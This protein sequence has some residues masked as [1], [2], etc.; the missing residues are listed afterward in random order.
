MFTAIEFCAS[1]CLSP[2]C[3]H[4]KRMKPIVYRCV[5]GKVFKPKSFPHVLKCECGAT[6]RV[7]K[8]T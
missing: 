6:I 5:C 7:E 4:D 2:N 8:P 3:V 1:Y